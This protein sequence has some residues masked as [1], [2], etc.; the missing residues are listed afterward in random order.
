M[1]VF[2][3][4]S[5]HLDISEILIEWHEILATLLQTHG[6][7]HEAAGAHRPGSGRGMDGKLDPEELGFFLGD[8]IF[9]SENGEK[10][11]VTSRTL[12]LFCTSKI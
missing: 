3:A 9:A 1:F 2:S 8:P 5:A 12:T 10:S 6:R 11:Q 4:K 7:L